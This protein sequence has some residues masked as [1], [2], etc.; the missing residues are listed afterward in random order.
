[1]DLEASLGFGRHREGCGRD[2]NVLIVALEFTRCDG[3]FDLCW[4]LDIDDLAHR[5][6]D[7]AGQLDGVDEFGLLH[8]H[9]HEVESIF[10]SLVSFKSDLEAVLPTLQAQEVQL[11]LFG[12]LTS[13]IK[14]VG[15][16]DE[17]SG[18][19]LALYFPRGMESLWDLGPVL[20]WDDDRLR[21]LRS[22]RLMKL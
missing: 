16:A 19:S 6:S 21:P 20:D 13:N 2:L 3:D 4:V 12:G 8:S 7:L 10:A 15:S 5:L 22:D 14:G 17:Q 18:I 11:V 9:I 1:M